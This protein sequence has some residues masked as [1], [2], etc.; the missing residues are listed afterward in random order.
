MATAQ[1]GRW[2][3]P[4]NQSCGA[5]GAPAL[6]LRGEKPAERLAEIMEQSFKMGGYVCVPLKFTRGKFLVQGSVNG[7]EAHFIVDT[8]GASTTVD[9]DQADNFQIQARERLGRAV[10]GHWGAAD[11]VIVWEGVVV[12]H[13]AVQAGKLS[14]GHCGSRK[15]PGKKGGELAV[16][17]GS[18]GAGSAG[19]SARVD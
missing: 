2:Q 5:S 6:Y 15:G 18:G 19:P 12:E 4:S 14:S 8:G 10:R 1:T 7:R 17:A 13:R 16:G 9:L 11:G 3:T